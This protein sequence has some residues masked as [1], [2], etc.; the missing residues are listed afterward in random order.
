M[1][2]TPLWVPLVVAALAVLGT[3]GGVYVTQRRSDRREAIAWIREP[4]RE[5]ERWARED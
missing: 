3:L 2:S 4:Q 5:R 1:S